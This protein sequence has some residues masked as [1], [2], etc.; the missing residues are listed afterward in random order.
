[1]T[2]SS[3]LRSQ[4]T[5]SRWL[6]RGGWPADESPNARLLINPMRR[7]ATA[8]DVCPSSGDVSDSMG[9]T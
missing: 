9:H 4:S 7:S 3:V 2:M 8:T 6:A 1:M 5:L